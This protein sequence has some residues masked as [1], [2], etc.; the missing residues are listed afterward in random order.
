MYKK[1]SKAGLH[2]LAEPGGPRHLTLALGQLE[3]LS[4]FHSND[5]LG[6]LDFT[7]PEHWPPF[8]FPY[9][10]ALNGKLS[11]PMLPKKATKITLF[12]SSC[13]KSSLEH[14]PKNFLP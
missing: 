2:R 10:T 14:R 8:N 4:F 9:S 3:N 11:C 13:S 5:M 12:N 1:K 6:T 7:G